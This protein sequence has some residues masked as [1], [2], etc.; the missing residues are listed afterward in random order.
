MSSFF[1]AKADSA[2]FDKN[3]SERFSRSFSFNGVNFIP[4]HDDCTKEGYNSSYQE[5]TLLV[6]SK[7]IGLLQEPM[8]TFI[9]N[10]QQV[11]KDG[12]VEVDNYIYPIYK[13]VMQVMDFHEEEFESFIS[14]KAEF[15]EEWLRGGNLD[16]GIFYNDFYEEKEE[17]FI[18]E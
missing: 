11:K 5:V 8:C 15:F 12:F 18:D 6:T 14:K 1:P 7:K 17:E 10:P 13:K 3:P 9:W 4:K 16:I 2:Y